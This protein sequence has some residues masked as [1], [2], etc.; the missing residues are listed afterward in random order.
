MIACDSQRLP[1]IFILLILGLADGVTLIG[2]Y[3]N[4]YLVILVEFENAH[5]AEGLGVALQ[6]REEHAV[7]V[8]ALL[9]GCLPIVAFLR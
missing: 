5:T 9:P 2:L 4:N 6:T 8:G 3:G 1:L 7:Y